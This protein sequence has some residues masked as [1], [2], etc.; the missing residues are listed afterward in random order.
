MVSTIRLRYFVEQRRQRVHILQAV[1]ITEWI[2][3]VR[4][5]VGF[6][7][8]TRLQKISDVP[9]ETVGRS[10]N[11]NVNVSAGHAGHRHDGDVPHV[12]L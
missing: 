9:A 4:L 11:G 5:R 12:A 2:Q 6:P 8:K 3:I 7:E 10:G 1:K